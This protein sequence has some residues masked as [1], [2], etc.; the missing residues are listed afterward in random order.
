MHRWAC[1]AFTLSH[2]YDDPKAVAAKL[3]SDLEARFRAA[4][5]RNIERF[6]RAFQE[7]LAAGTPF[8]EENANGDDGRSTTT[9][10]AG[11]PTDAHAALAGELAAGD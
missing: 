6:V 5:L 9:G 1:E 7:W 4:L 11:W 3:R 10:P 2:A 8:Y